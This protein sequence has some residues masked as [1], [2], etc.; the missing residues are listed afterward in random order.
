MALFVLGG[1]AAVP[2]STR[3]DLLAT[4]TRAALEA[5]GLLDAVGVVEID[6]GIRRSKILIPGQVFSR[7]AGVQVIDELSLAGG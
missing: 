4:P 3:T 1:L 2:A 6:P 5:A 7:L